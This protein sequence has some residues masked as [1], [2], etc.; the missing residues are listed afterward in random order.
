MRDYKSLGQIGVVML[1]LCAFGTIGCTRSPEAKM[2]KYMEAGKK[3]AEQKDY[4]AAILQ[5]RNASQAMPKNPEP[6]YQTGMAYLALHDWANAAFSLR[7]ALAFDPKHIGAQ[8]ALAELETATPDRPTVELA[9]KQLQ[10]LLTS[11]PDNPEVLTTLALADW[12]LAKPE[13]A[14]KH[15][16]EALE[17]FP[18][19]LSAAGGLAKVKMAKGDFAGAE[20][21]LKK[22]AAN[23]PPN[24]DAV[25]LLGAFYANRKNDV[26]ADAQFRRALQIDP[27]NISALF[28]S[29]ALQ[30]RQGKKDQAGQT[31]QNISTLDSKYRFVYASYLWEEDKRDAAIAEYQR[32]FAASPKDREVRT[33]LVAALFAANRTQDADKLLSEAIKKNDKD[34]DALLQRS[35][36]NIDSRRFAEARRDLQEVQRNQNS[37]TV[38]YLLSRADNAE[39]HQLSRRDHLNE[40]LRLEPNYLAA[41][42]ELAGLLL[43]SNSARLA[44]TL[45]DQTPRDQ[46]N[47]P[48]TIAMRNWALIAAGDSASAKKTVE[49]VIDHARTPDLLL[50][51]SMFKLADKQ[52]EEA[53]KL[54]REGLAQAPDSKNL[55]TA[56]VMTYRV[57]NQMPAAVQEIKAHAAQRPNS[58]SVQI[59]LGELLRQTGDFS[60]AATAF[61]AAKTANPRDVQADLQ[62]ARLYQQ[63]GKL[64]EA[65]RSLNTVLTTDTNN[66]TALIWRGDIEA[67]KG[68]YNSAVADYRR[69]LEFDSDNKLALNNLSF[70]LSEYLHQQDEALSYA[71][72]ALQL[73][74]NDPATQDTLG[75]I[76][77]RKG[78]YDLS[79][80][81]LEAAAEKPGNAVWKYHLAMAY[82]RLGERTKARDAYDAARRLN[83]DLPEAKEASELL[84]LRKPPGN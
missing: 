25:S 55:L 75:W 47:L 64:D 22:A 39:G 49:A 50:Q 52:Y 43:R 80:K 73:S 74:P 42:L 61:A 53:R 38:Q 82:A 23:T 83:T 13:E 10:T 31:Y 84:A 33:R 48:Q 7:K 29:A 41:R 9:E 68:D 5:F 28:N 63:Q 76:L 71:Q 6:H 8:L 30:V 81:Q 79:V 60:G 11:A 16:Q 15:L 58:F 17:K 3:L 45:M 67:G 46:K 18:S 57:Q 36:L 1:T 69:V 54:V 24:A 65:V 21:V 12:R 2:A 40:A 27:K 14:E 37:G 56:L 34:I 32:M 70:I 44:L 35:R 51:A 72:R 20:D 59:F 19:N 66:R 4:R 62:Y 26:E 77:Y 78:M